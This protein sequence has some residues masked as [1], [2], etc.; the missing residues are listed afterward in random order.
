MRE[1]Q[2]P[3]RDL[4]G[5]FEGRVSLA[6]QF[7]RYAHECYTHG[8]AASCALLETVKDALARREAFNEA[9][10]DFAQCLGE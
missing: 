2:K 7:E 1:C 10:R 4:L 6:A 8:D 9:M 5:I 3:L